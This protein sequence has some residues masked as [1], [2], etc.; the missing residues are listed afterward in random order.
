MVPRLWCPAVQCPECSYPNDHDFSFCQRCGYRRL[1]QSQQSVNS[2]IQLDLPSI[3]NRLQSIQALRA[4]KPYE[5]QRSALQKELENFLFSLPLSKSLSSAAPQ[6]LVRFLIYKDRKGKTKVHKS[7]CPLFGSHSKERCQCPVRLAAGT[8]DSL[9]GKLRSI[10]NNA[11]RAGP[12]CDLLGTGNPASYHSLKDYLRFLYQEQ[13]SSH[14]S[15]KQSVPIFLD[16]LWK[17]CQHLNHLAYLSCDTAPLNRYI[18]A[19]DLAFF[20][21]DFFSGDRASDLGRTLTK[22]VLSLPDNQG[23]IFRQSVGKTLRGKDFHV[24]AIR[25]CSN[26]LICP[27]SSLDRYVRLC[28]LF[29]VDLREGYLFRATD[30]SN[31]VAEKPFV[32]STVAAR[33]TSYLTSLGIS[34]G[35]TMHSFRSG[36]SITL[37]MLGVPLADIARHVGWRSTQMAQYYCQTDKV[38]GLTKPADTLAAATA[39]SKYDCSPALSSGRVF[40][41]LNNLDGFKMAFV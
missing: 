15:P 14:V 20:C 38:L 32:G 27:V 6:D 41:S 19:R 9:I 8:V 2:K 33:L 22:E 7:T 1:F 21:V 11:G 23:F 25:K 24:F 13:A 29:N 37:S 30:K 26:P 28:K 35:E 10:F 12:W 31:K 40:S 16:K 18:F 4:S 3:N 5:K 17:L 34:E 36:C 39:P